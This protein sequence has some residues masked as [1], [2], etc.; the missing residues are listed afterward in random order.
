MKKRQ[1]DL[2]ILAVCVVWAVLVLPRSFTGRW[3]PG[4]EAAITWAGGALRL[5]LLAVAAFA[6]TYG[7][8]L[9]DK[10]NPARSSQSLLAGGFIIYLLAQATLFVL[11]LTSGDGTPPYP[12]VADLGFFVAMVLL[13]AGVAMAIRSWLVLGLFPDGG[14]RAAAAAVVAAVPLAVGVV[15][16]IRSL[17]GA[18]STPLQEAADIT[19]P[20]LDSILLILIVAMLRLTML[21][22]KGTVGVV[23]RSLLLGFLAMAIGD[24]V[25]SFF[26]GFNLD[27]LDPVLDVLYTVAYALMARGALLQLRLLRE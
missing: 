26:A 11:T 25:Y 16:T 10:T 7:T 14:R 24:V 1:L 12:S 27:T 18:A 23:W 22:G 3:S 19:Y 9:L 4:A 21:L 8:R 6:A 5:A 15:F 2:V 20:V 17:A 13:I